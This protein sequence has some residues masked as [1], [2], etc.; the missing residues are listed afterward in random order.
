MARG[1]AGEV[2]RRLDSLF[3]PGTVAGL[4]EGPLLDR[5]VARGDGAE[6]AFEAIVARHG[7]MVWG[8][9]RHA[10]RDPND[11]EDAFQATFLIL[12]RRAG[13]IRQRDRL[14]G[15]LH[16]VACRV[17]ARARRDAA[18]RPTRDA[19]ALTVE[20]PDE[21][22]RRE[23]IALLHEELARLPDKYRH[24]IV[25]CH[26]EGCT[27]DEA[28]ARLGWPVGT[29]RGRLSRGRDRLRDQLSRRGLAIGAAIPTTWPGTTMPL[30][31]PDVLA[32]HTVSAAVRFA[33]GQEAARVLSAQG[34]AWV[35]GGLRAMM[36]KPIQLIAVVLATAGVVTAGAGALALAQGG[37]RDGQVVAAFPP[38]QGEVKVR[39]DAKGF[40]ATRKYAEV[41]P[42]DAANLEAL[43]RI[44]DVKIQIG[45]LQAKVSHE[46][47]N[48]V[49]LTKSLKV[50]EER[51]SRGVDGLLILRG[52]MLGP[53]PPIESYLQSGGNPDIP[54]SEEMIRDAKE[55]RQ[56]DAK[57]AMKNAEQQVQNLKADISKQREQYVKDQAELS[58]LQK[59]LQSL[60]RQAEG[61]AGKTAEEDDEKAARAEAEVELLQ[62]DVENERR[63]F[64]ALTMTL[65]DALMQGAPLQ[66]GPREVLERYHAEKINRLEVSIRNLREKYLHDRTELANRQR[67][68][69]ASPRPGGG[70]PLP[71]ELERR[72][73]R[74]E[75]AVDA[76]REAVEKPK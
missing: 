23:R 56:K 29:V 46:F 54:A 38:P 36:V 51:L 15:W 16:G 28:A 58:R 59:E 72:L 27:H 13:A 70:D 75:T 50:S 62:V 66:P 26:L 44:A 2:L 14:G 9:C 55:R 12:A 42:A 40:P 76:I 41:K 61:P 64:S 3:G 67:N 37:G 10:L 17:S 49:G 65:S 74:I 31:V 21:T 57:K 8:V 69:R 24:P 73:S 47:N 43:V 7:P 25:L 32:N 22:E 1:Y 4:G 20:A 18:R 19:S 39:L 11:A 63:Q 6:A 30:A 53:L 71:P 33:A 5:F 60:E 34:A 68:L 52:N 45:V 35:E 48:L